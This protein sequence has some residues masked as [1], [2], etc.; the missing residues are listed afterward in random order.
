MHNEYD[1]FR[2]DIL[3]EEDAIAK[4]IDHL[5][6]RNGVRGVLLKR[7]REK[8]E[9]EKEKRNRT[10]IEDRHILSFSQSFLTSILRYL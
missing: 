9:R 1:H 5:S 4:V 3:R 6:R 8:R 10:G 7:E 2:S